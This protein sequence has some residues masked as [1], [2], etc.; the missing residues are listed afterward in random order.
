MNCATKN[1][2]HKLEIINID[3]FTISMYYQLTMLELQMVFKSLHLWKKWT[4]FEKI[5]LAKPFL[6]SW[7]KNRW[8]AQE[9]KETN[10]NRLG[11]EVRWEVHGWQQTE[12]HS[13][14]NHSK[15]NSER[16][17]LGLANQ[18]DSHWEGG[19]WRVSGRE[20][21]D[22]ILVPL[23]KGPYNSESVYVRV[24]PGPGGPSLRA[25]G[26][27]FASESMCG[28]PW[29]GPGSLLCDLIWRVPGPPFPTLCTLRCQAWGGGGRR[30]KR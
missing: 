6:K 22:D 14:K 29:R 26:S 28:T 15:I 12:Q 5:F 30:G 20:M 4:V 17:M 2:F 13:Q 7:E 11:Q 18:N 9:E 25:S 16:K 8:R 3:R 19:K 27:L 21:R 24:C 23:L 1:V 10:L